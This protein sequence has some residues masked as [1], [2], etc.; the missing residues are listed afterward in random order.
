MSEL[1]TAKF[2]STF[3]MQRLILYHEQ[4]LADQVHCCQFKHFVS[5]G[6]NFVVV[7]YAWFV[8]IGLIIACA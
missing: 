2:N 1:V 3:V 8:A 5:H 6:F 7:L 4:H